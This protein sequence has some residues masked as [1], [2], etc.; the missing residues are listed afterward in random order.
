[1][2]K[3]ASKKN[4]ASGLV[5]YINGFT[6]G[7]KVEYKKIKWPKQQDAI[8]QTIA[9]IVITVVLG[10]IITAFDA[11]LQVGIQFLTQIG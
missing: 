1:M 10:L 6:S 2:V 11:V 4:I 9:V 5:A 3:S 8:K 7:V